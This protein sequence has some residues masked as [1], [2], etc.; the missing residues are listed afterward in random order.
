[1]KT[2]VIVIDDSRAA[3]LQISNVLL[4]AGYDI[5]EAEDGREGLACIDEHTDAK[6]VICDLNMPKLS[7][8]DLL[9]L[10][11]ASGK[12]Q[13]AP[14]LM[15][16]TE[17]QP[18]L[19]QEAKNNG[20]K[21]WIMKPFKPE[22]LLAAVRKLAVLG[23]SSRRWRARPYG[24]A[25]GYPMIAFTALSNRS[26][27]NGLTIQPFAPR[28]FARW[29]PSTSPSVVS[30]TTGTW[31]PAAREHSTNWCP[32]IRGMLTSHSTIAVSRFLCRSVRPC[33]PSSASI[34]S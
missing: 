4:G 8:L 9:A 34:T 21:G 28:L 19:V 23:R 26:A 6:L 18:S 17:A 31:W 32:L 30:I 29:T 13:N 20:A 11:K 27:L 1:M 3:R 12:I 10:L 22:L 24:G 25:P 2:K 5:I 14:F 15:L 7:G 33:T 16:T